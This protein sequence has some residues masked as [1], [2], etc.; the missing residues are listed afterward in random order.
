VI[1]PGSTI[2]ARIR[3]ERNGFDGELKFDVDNLPHGV[4]VDNIGL[5]GIMVR[6][7]ETE[8]QVFLTA[9]GWVPETTHAIHAVALGEGNQASRPITLHVRRPGQVAT[10]KP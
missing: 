4:I 3:I 8:R 10:A 2:T 5:N 6:K 9:S 1:A 7:G